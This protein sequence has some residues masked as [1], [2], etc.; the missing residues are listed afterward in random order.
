MCKVSK[1]KSQH[2]VFNAVAGLFKSKQQV[3]LLERE[4]KPYGS[5]M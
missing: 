2:R 1:Q 3:Q 5:C 4:G